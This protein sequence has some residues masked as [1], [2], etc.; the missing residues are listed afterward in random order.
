MSRTSHPA[1]PDQGRRADS[2]DEEFWTETWWRDLWTP[3][4]DV[5]PAH[6]PSWGPREPVGAVEAWGP[7]DTAARVVRAEWEALRHERGSGGRVLPCPRLAP[8]EVR[9]IAGLD[10]EAHGGGGW[11]QRGSTTTAG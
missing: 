9:P 4:A 2:G 7:A 11:R 10:D 6:R 1:R 3:E 5:V 8:G